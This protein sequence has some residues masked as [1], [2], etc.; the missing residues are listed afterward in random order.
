MPNEFAKLYVQFASTINA[1]SNHIYTEWSVV[2]CAACEGSKGAG[3][4]AEGRRALV[5]QAEARS[6]YFVARALLLDKDL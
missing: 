2:R 3:G 4:C 6:A 1:Y 5:L